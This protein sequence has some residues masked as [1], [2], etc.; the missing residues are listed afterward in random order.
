MTDFRLP[1]PSPPFSPTDSRGSG[2]TGPGSGIR[3]PR[4]EEGPNDAASSVD[5][6]ARIF[7]TAIVA[8][9]AAGGLDFSGE[10]FKVMQSPPFKAILNSIR[11]HARAQGITDRE[12]A[13]Q[14]IR[15]FRGIDQLWKNYLI[16][17]GMDR[18]ISCE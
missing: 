4:V 2:G 5:D 11:Q 17:E 1:D 8:T 3:S 13:E 9:Q 10:L 12:A 14:V 15:A 16:Q 6:L 18:L 7:N